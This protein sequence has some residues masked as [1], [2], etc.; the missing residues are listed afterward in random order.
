M[1]EVKLK[2]E[3]INDKLEEYDFK[4]MC[5]AS[6]RGLVAES[7]AH[8]AGV[9]IEDFCERRWVF[10]TCPTCS[11]QTSLVKLTNQLETLMFEREQNDT[12]QA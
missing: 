8:D 5:G 4:C 7:Y 3:F 6:L 2:M 1:E 10:V 11:Y 12:P 9:Y